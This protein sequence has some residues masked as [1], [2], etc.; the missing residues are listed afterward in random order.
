MDTIENPFND[1]DENMVMLNTIVECI[2]VVIPKFDN[3][4]M[5]PTYHESNNTYVVKYIDNIPEFMTKFFNMVW[6]LQSQ[7]NEWSIVD[8]LTWLSKLIVTYHDNK[9]VFSFK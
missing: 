7:D 6:E 5:F 8:Y 3:V 2:L 9:L 1:M 4:D